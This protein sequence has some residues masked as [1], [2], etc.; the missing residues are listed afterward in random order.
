MPCDHKFKNELNLER[1]DFEPTTLIVGT[2]VPGWPANTA[3]WF[4]GRTRDADGNMINNFWDVLPRLYGEQ[5]LIDAGPQEWKQFCREKQIALTDLISSI[6]DA[7]AD[8]A[9]HNKVF[10]GFADKALIF[11]FDDFVFVNIV[12]LLRRHPSIKNVYLTRGITESFWKHLWNPVIQYCSLNNI[13]ERR[14]LT[15]AG[16]DLYEHTAYNNEHPNWPIPLLQ[17]YILMRWKQ[18]W[19]L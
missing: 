11:N 2:F 10:A 1:I 12:Q 18:E 9:A 7:D 14:L 16:P 19:H 6:D 13:R 3:D 5:S 8:N 17:D 15:P 4:Y